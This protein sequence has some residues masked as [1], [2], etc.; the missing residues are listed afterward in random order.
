MPH[1]VL[2]AFLTFSFLVIS[3]PILLLDKLWPSPPSSLKNA[4]LLELYLLTW[5][6][7]VASTVATN[8]LHIGGVYLIAA[9]NMCAWLAALVAV[10][11]IATQAGRGQQHILNLVGEANIS[12]EGTEGHRFVQG[13]MYQ[14]PEGDGQERPDE[15]VETEP[16]EITPLIQQHRRRSTGGREYV[17]GVDNEPLLVNSAS[18]KT[19][20]S[21][22]DSGW[23]ILE[24][25]V[26]VPLP[27]LLLFQIILILQHSLRNTMVD[28]GSPVTGPPSYLI[29]IRVN[30]C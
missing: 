4:S 19:S 13:I 22:P 20:D 9:W 28:G 12:S 6:L 30:V 29:S 23:W 8:N 2:I 10:C 17:V 25:I 16:T 15:E 3:V 14:Q 26:L 5:I 24:L 18:S 7:L 1:L 11:E 21:G 27:S